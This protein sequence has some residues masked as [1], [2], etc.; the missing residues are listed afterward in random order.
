MR[1]VRQGL[2]DA[3][4]ISKIQHRSDF[5][6]L[7][8]RGCRVVPLALVLLPAP[9]LLGAG[10]IRQTHTPY[11]GN[12]AP[13]FLKKEVPVRPENPRSKISA[14]SAEGTRTHA[15]LRLFRPKP[16]GDSSKNELGAIGYLSRAPG[17][18]RWVVVLPIWGSSTYPPKKIV[19]WLLS[20]AE[21]PQTN[22]LWIQEPRRLVRYQAFKDASTEAEFLAEA[23]RT[24]S[25]IEATTEDVRAF[26]DW[27]MEQPETDPRRVGIVG[28]SIGGIVGSLVMGR[29]PR[30]AAGVFVMVGAHLDEIVARCKWGQR[31]VRE[32][33]ATAFGWSAEKFQ[34]VLK[35]PLSAVDPALVSGRIDPAA[36][37]YINAGSDGCI[38]QSC[39]DDL[40]RAMGEPERVTLGYDHRNSF[41]TMTFLGFDVTTHRILEFLDRRLAKTDEPPTTKANSTPI[42]G[43][44]P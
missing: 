27:V 43:K 31:E 40:W 32:H 35:V 25:C 38:P 11:H 23:S 9:C 16:C 8:L 29:D 36:V 34:S 2:H 20:G 41:L 37:L 6:L 28:F 21:G 24:A 39:R 5:F 14:V 15:I 33:A 1:R 18:K 3:R 42:K 4:V 22:V 44:A 19:R 13:R 30:F 17:A 10:C 26:T 12:R 7:S